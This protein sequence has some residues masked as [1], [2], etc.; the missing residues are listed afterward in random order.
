MKFGFFTLLILSVGFSV[1]GIYLTRLGLQWV[2]Y[3]S[4]LLWPSWLLGAWIASLHRENKLSKLK[5]V[6]VSSMLI[7]FLV[8]A[9]ASR[10]K[11]WEGWTQYASWTGFY[12]TLFLVFLRFEKSITGLRENLFFKSLAWLGQISFSL[13]LIHFPLFKLFGFIHLYYFQEKP[14]NFIISLAYMIPV[15][16][17]AWIFYRLIE[18]PIHKWSKRLIK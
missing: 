5:I 12:F 6:P 13:Y 2:S 14:A 11:N 18:H 16:F 3:T 17:L 8:I 9:L 15:F 10:L 1:L 7:L 4:L